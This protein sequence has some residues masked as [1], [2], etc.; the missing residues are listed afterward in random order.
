MAQANVGLS[1]KFTTLDP[2]SFSFYGFDGV[3]L[4][5]MERRPRIARIR[6]GAAAVAVVDD[7]IFVPSVRC[8]IPGHPKFR[9]GVVT[10]DGRPIALAHLRR[11]GGIVGGLTGPLAVEPQRDV[12]EEAIYLGWLFNHFGHFLLESL[13][14][15]WYLAQAD[16]SVRVVFQYP[17][18]ANPN[19]PEWAFRFLEAFGV[20]RHR[21]VVLD[22][23]TRLRRMIVP[24]PLFELQ[25]AAYEQAAQPYR[26]VASNVVGD[27]KP[28][29][30]PV[31]LSR[32][33]LSTKQ[34]M[35]V[36]EDELEEILRDNGFLIVYPEKMSFEDQVR[37]FNRHTDIFSTTGSAAHNVL[38]A[39]NK[40]SLHILANE[41]RFSPNYYLCSHL[42]GAPTTFI[43]CLSTRGLPRLDEA[44]RSTPDFIELP[45]I[46]EYL[47]IRGYLTKPMGVSSVNVGAARQDRYY[48]TWLYTSVRSAI[49]RRAALPAQVESQALTYAT[50]SW[51]V[52]SILAAYYAQDGNSL[53]DDLVE[54]FITLLASELDKSR[55]AALKSDVETMVKRVSTRCSPATVQRLAEVCRTVFSRP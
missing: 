1:K 12:D 37:L 9:G 7:A 48:E 54:Q 55:L 47:S 26:A 46:V 28:T 16:P 22:V 8:R 40:P 17:D 49:Q 10:P 36:N 35:T 18:P 39:L 44:V 50:S 27:A 21:I 11:G 43:N 15:I 29:T 38:F 32:R 30:Q 33:F 45:K 14:R 42:A 5:R 51:P 20:P 23:P 6:C 3:P 2:K 52:T 4:R 41:L 53:K 25:F 19:A 31:Y 24:E 34:R 13:A